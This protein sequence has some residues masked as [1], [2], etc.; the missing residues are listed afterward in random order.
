VVS[1]YTANDLRIREVDYIR[2]TGRSAQHEAI[3]KSLVPIEKEVVDGLKV[4][5]ESL[6]QD[7]SGCVTPAD[8][9]SLRPSLME[10]NQFLNEIYY[11]LGIREYLAPVSLLDATSDQSELRVLD[12]RF[13]CP[14]LQ[15]NKDLVLSQVIVLADL[16]GGWFLRF[17]CGFG[18]NAR[19]AVPADFE[20]LK[21][22]LVYLMARCGRY[23]DLF[24]SSESILKRNALYVPETELTGSE[25]NKSHARSEEVEMNKLALAEAA[26]EILELYKCGSYSPSVLTK[27]GKPLKSRVAAG[28]IQ[29]WAQL[30]TKITDLPEIPLSNNRLSRT[31]R[32]SFSKGNGWRFL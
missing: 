24:L 15:A 14:Y 6:E 1:T 11:P 31:L 29:N 22:E 8:V 5:F 19:A 20:K 26:N 17:L 16:Q 10:I 21:A 23:C 9:L 4:L 32:L 18:T 2:V 25:S 3:R 13:C 28:V 12:N 30:R 7:F 27:E